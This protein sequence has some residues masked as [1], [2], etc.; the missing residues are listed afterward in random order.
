M[1]FF[2]SL[3]ATTLLLVAM[4]PA[5]AASQAAAPGKLTHVAS[6]NSKVNINTADAS[7]L[8][9]IKGV[10][11]K[12]AQAIIQWRKQQGPFKTV[13]QLL[14]IK[15]IGEKTLQRMRGQVSLH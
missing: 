7:E 11:P 3:I 15:G 13:D 14:A 6:V 12:T 1:R 4:T 2:Q 9:K 5:L 8:Q 10:G